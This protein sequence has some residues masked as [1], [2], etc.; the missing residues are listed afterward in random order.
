LQECPEILVAIKESG[1]ESEVHNTLIVRGILSRAWTDCQPTFYRGMFTECFFAFL[2]VWVAGDARNDHLPSTFVVLLIAALSVSTCFD[3]FV[4]LAAGLWT[5]MLGDDSLNAKSM[6]RMNRKYTFYQALSKVLCAG[7][8][9]GGF[10]SFTLVGINTV[11]ETP[12]RTARRDAMWALSVSALAQICGMLAVI[13]FCYFVWAPVGR[14]LQQSSFEAEGRA[15]SR[16]PTLGWIVALVL[17]GAAGYLE[18]HAFEEG[19]EAAPRPLFYGLAAFACALIGFLL[20]QCDLI[21]APEVNAMWKHIYVG[22][23]WTTFEF[24]MAIYGVALIAGFMYFGWN[25]KRVDEM[26][27]NPL[28]ETK[29]DLTRDHPTWAAIFIFFKVQ[30]VIQKT[31]CIRGI[32]ENVIPAYNALCDKASTRVILFAIMMWA[33]SFFT[34]YAIPVRLA[35]NWWENVWLVGVSMFRLDFSGDFQLD[36]LEGLDPTINLT[37]NGS[38]YFGSLSDNKHFMPWHKA[39]GILYMGCFFIMNIGFLNVYIGIVSNIYQTNY[40]RRKELFESYRAVYIYKIMVRRRA[41]SR[42]WKSESPSENGTVTPTDSEPSRVW[43]MYDPTVGGEK[44]EAAVIDLRKQLKREREETERERGEK[45]QVQ[46]QVREL[47]RKYDEE[48]R[49]ELET[50]REEMGKLGKIAED[51]SKTTKGKR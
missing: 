40:F 3:A 2:L 38:D 47:Q 10:I 12:D 4:E 17:L 34:Y 29:G 5:T 8:F 36:Q 33:N 19:G 42:F 1:V 45:E 23:F 43:L 9:L 18:Y 51:L 30:Q 7:A 48:K 25:I 49:I 28:L 37:R 44:D 50:L 39:V 15:T 41:S 13:V 11:R 35:D 31:L 20:F 46:L 22:Q 24:I 26:N 14:M 16:R 6:N 27:K 32:G 21:T